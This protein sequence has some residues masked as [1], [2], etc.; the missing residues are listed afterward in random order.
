MK[1]RILLAAL[2]VG[3]LAW[4]AIRASG[5]MVASFDDVNQ[6]GSNGTDYTLGFEFQVITS[7]QVGGLGVYDYN[8]DGLS[9][10]DAVGLWTSSGTLLASVTVPAGTAAPLDNWFR[11]APLASPLTL[12][13]G[14]YVVGARQGSDF[15]G[16]DPVNLTMAPG[17]VYLQDRYVRSGGLDYP[18][19]TENNAYG[20]GWFGG[21]VVV[22]PE[23]TTTVAGTAAGLFALLSLRNRRSQ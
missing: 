18:G 7:L 8:K 6:Y 2:N 3:A 13:P 9:Q 20:S 5:A 15:Y 17:T 10:A 14:T 21:N 22:V 1:R 19:S 4:A 11:W 16:W 23:P 12:Q